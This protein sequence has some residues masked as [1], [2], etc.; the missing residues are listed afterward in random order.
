MPPVANTGLRP[1][2]NTVRRSPLLCAVMAAALVTTFW[3]GMIWLA[4]RIMS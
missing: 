2:P 1:E 4:E 3:A